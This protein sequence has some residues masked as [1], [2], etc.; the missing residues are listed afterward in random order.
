MLSSSPISTLDNDYDNDED[1]Q[2][3]VLTVSK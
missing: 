2:V 3:T 1:R